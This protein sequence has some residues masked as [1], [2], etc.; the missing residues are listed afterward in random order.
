MSATPITVAATLRNLS[1]THT[2]RGKWD[3]CLPMS[4]DERRATWAARFYSAGHHHKQP[5]PRV[6]VAQS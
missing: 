6:R 4:D 2:K 1:V 3:G 5:K